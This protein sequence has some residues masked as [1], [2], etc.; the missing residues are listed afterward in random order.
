MPDA[1]L[2]ALC[3]FVSSLGEVVLCSF[4]SCPLPVASKNTY[5]FIIIG[6]GSSGSVLASRLSEDPSLSVL[7]LESGPTDKHPLVDVPL[8]SQFLQGT[9]RDWQMETNPQE[10]AC[11]EIAC[12]AAGRNAGAKGCCRW[13]LGRGLGGG[14]AINYMAYVR[15]NPGD[16][17]EW[18]AR[19][20]HFSQVLYLVGFHRKLTMALTFVENLRH[21]HK[22]SL[23]PTLLV[24]QHVPR[25]KASTCMPFWRIYKRTVCVFVCVCVCVCA[26][27]CVSIPL[28]L[29][30][31]LSLQ[32]Q[33]DG[34]TQQLIT[35]TKLLV[36]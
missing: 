16:F 29:S 35:S 15:G 32:A 8:G 23:K 1:T 4:R 12:S 26:C 7:V 19:G 18:Q 27:A 34:I 36:L 13:P 9:V 3:D 10:N 25:L 17:N 5:D 6:G 30:L 28:N 11:G 22:F 14:S 21:T 24:R 33:R 2:I 20:A 31:S